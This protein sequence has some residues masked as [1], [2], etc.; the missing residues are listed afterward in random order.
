MW[1]VE[2]EIITRGGQRK[3]SH[4]IARPQRQPDGSVLWNGIILDATRIK[5]AN[6]ALAASN[7]AK[8][9]FLANMSHELRTPLNAIIGFSD[10]IRGEILG[11]IGNSRYKG[12]ADDIYASGMHLLEIIND[13]LDLAKI[14]TGKLELIEDAFD[15]GP[16]IENSVRLV[17]DRAKANDIALTIDLPP[18][19]PRVHADGRKIKQILINLLSNAVKFT[20][21]GGKVAVTACADASGGIAMSVADTGIGIAPEHMTKVLE[22]FA[23]VDSSL[24]RKFEGTGLGLSLTKAMIELHGGSLLLES[25]VGVGTTVTVRLPRERVLD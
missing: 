12:Y 16:A 13:I 15:L 14:E 8:S 18:N 20:P 10:V 24:N 2:A 23:Q 17:H 6:L 21:K 19:L 5:E 4:A 22:P 7:R 25:R 3:W 1:D 9:E 11:E